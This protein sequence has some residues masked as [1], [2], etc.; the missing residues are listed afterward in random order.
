MGRILVGVVLPA[1]LVNDVM[2]ERHVS[3]RA[4]L[5][6]WSVFVFV[7]VEDFPYLLSDNQMVRI[8]LAID[9]I[10]SIQVTGGSPL[11]SGQ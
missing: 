9:E 8:R 11:A 5:A 7:F 1:N 6:R 4:G 3:E 10:S 2:A